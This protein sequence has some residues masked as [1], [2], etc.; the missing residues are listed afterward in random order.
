VRNA[1]AVTGAGKVDLLV[2]GA[3][4]AGC[5]AAIEAL[6][7]GARVTLLDRARFPRP[8][9]CGDALSNQAVQIVGELGAELEHVPR[10]IVRRS[11]AVFPDGSRVER[12]YA[13]Q[14]GAI[15]AR[16]ELDDL[17]R[18]RAEDAGARVLEGV[19]I[20]D[21][22][23]L[24]GGGAR[25]SGRAGSWDADVVIAADGPASVAWCALGQRAPRGRA[26][27][28]AVTAYYEGVSVD[29]ADT[30]EHYFEPGLAAGYGW[31]FP[32]VNGI[33]NVGVYQ[34]ADRYHARGA[35][36][37]QLLERFVANHPERF[38]RARRVGKSRNWPLPLAGLRPF[39]GTNGVL[40]C[41]DAAR[42]VDPLTG[43]GIWHALE[44]GRLAAQTALE[45]LSG[46]GVDRALLHRYAL[47]LGLSVGWPSASRRLVQTGIDLLVAHQLHR[48]AAVRALL[49]WGYTAGAFEISKRVAARQ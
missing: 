8:K 38:A 36:L 16:L 34:R 13:A 17:L 27:A 7:S 45:A 15:V 48:S 43:E 9:P 23:P 40:A 14:P 18:R 46:N 11:A 37:S 26:L 6:R 35:Q 5:A 1:V 41:G 24:R 42:L 47:R 4:P 20:R 28:V 12:G 33:A 31:I 21:L 22:C 25:A 30:S 49:R 2:I 32:A 29:Q 39:S 19:A 3:G 10:A 44:S